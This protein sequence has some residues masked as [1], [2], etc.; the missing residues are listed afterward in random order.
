MSEISA[1]AKVLPQDRVPFRSPWPDSG[2]SDLLCNGSVQNKTVRFG[3]LEPAHVTLAKQCI[4]PS[5]VVLNLAIC[6]LIYGQRLSLEFYALGLVAFLIAAQI[7]SPLDLAIHKGTER[8]WGVVS[9]VLLEWSCVVAVLVFLAVSFRLTH[10]FSR[11]TILSWFL[12][13][14]LALLL[15]DS[16]RNPVARWL[17]SQRAITD[18]YIIIGANEVGIELSR[19]IEQ[20]DAGGKFLGFLDFRSSERLSEVVDK[21]VTGNCSARDLADFVRGHAISRVYLALPICTAPRIEELLKELRDTTASVYF[22][23]NI[24]AFDLVQARCVEIDGMPAFSICDSPLQGM[25]SVWKRVFDVALASI[26]LLLTWPALLVVALAIKLSSPGPVLFKQRRY[27]LNGEEILI[28]KFRSMT[29]CEDGCDVAQATQRDRRVTRFGAFL[30]RSSLDELPQILNVLEG[31][32]SF[33]GPRPHAVAHNE[34]YRKLINGYMIRHKVR[35]GITGW[36][37]VNGLRGETSTVDKMHRRVQYDLDYLRN[38]SLWLDV[39]I[40]ARTALMVVNDR[41]AY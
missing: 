10:V 22:V 36:A 27:G 20:S 3:S 39:K 8:M 35:P 33:V 25:S 12:A 7:F 21:P 41:N 30:R 19:R 5:V 9:R 13:T 29:V 4:L 28:Y 1:S 18:R 26:T 38:W 6:V 23:P 37:Q 15:V 24:F 11:D 31:K 2:T 40:I 14:P 34:T 32:M 17:A 16:L